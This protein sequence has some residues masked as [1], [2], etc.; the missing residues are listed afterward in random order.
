VPAGTVNVAYSNQLME[1]LHPDDAMLQLRHLYDALA[2]NGI[3]ICTTP[4]RL[5]GPH[6][7]SGGF[8]RTP[9]GF[10]LKEYTA[11]EL[12]RTFRQTGFSKTEIIWRV[13]GRY[14]RSS[15][16]L[17]GLCERLV[18]VIPYPLGRSRI[19][20]HI[21]SSVLGIVIIGTK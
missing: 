21:L 2:K 9:T 11:S 12:A 20:Y 18:N 7:I 13:R 19:L 6:D 8:D 15:I 10:H 16:I 17:T 5:T 1:H 4:N 3:C 14:L